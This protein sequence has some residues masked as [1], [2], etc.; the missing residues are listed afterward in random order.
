MRDSWYFL[1]LR[2]DLFI[3]KACW[4]CFVTMCP[5]QKTQVVT[6]LNSSGP[7]C[8]WADFSFFLF[9]SL[10]L[11]LYFCYWYVK[12]RYEKNW[13]FVRSLVKSLGTPA[14]HIK[15]KVCPCLPRSFEAHQGQSLRPSSSSP[16]WGMVEPCGTSTCCDGVFRDSA[17]GRLLGANR[18][19]R[20]QRLVDMAKEEVMLGCFDDRNLLRF[21]KHVIINVNNRHKCIWIA[22]CD[23][24][25]DYILQPSLCHFMLL[26][27][28]AWWNGW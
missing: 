4:H 27:F 3:L 23:M 19:T 15:L 8:F 18:E 5:L 14:Q 13:V 24:L 11:S 1:I 10:S 21:G 12:F 26:N 25:K 2:G 17:P 16:S 20:D 28:W 22:R 9:V 6:R 7:W